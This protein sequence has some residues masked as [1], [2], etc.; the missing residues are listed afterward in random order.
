MPRG[1]VG[2]AAARYLTGV[3]EARKNAV[4]SGDRIVNRANSEN[5]RN[6]VM[7]PANTMNA[8]SQTMMRHMNAARTNSRTLPALTTP[9]ERPLPFS[10]E[11]AHTGSFAV[12]RGNSSNIVADYNQYLEVCRTINKAEENMGYCLHSVATEIEALC[13]SAFVMP[14]AVPRCLNISDTVK[15]SLDQARHMTDDILMESRRFADTITGIGL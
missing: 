4:D 14:S 2:N 1:F 7:A 6:Q 13:Q 11:D 8:N 5:A 15:C 12:G 10:P 9:R 3:S